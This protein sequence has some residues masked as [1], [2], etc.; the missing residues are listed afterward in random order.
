MQK[1]KI[2]GTV[3][4]Y[5]YN[6]FTEYKVYWRKQK[7]NLIKTIKEAISAS[8]CGIKIEQDMFV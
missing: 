5:I 6:T 2:V 7:G 1:L 4:T 3:H 8:N